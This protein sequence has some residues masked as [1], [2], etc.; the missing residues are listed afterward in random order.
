MYGLLQ[1]VFHL[2]LRETMLEF[3]FRLST[4]YQL[5]FILIELYY[6]LVRYVFN[7]EKF[8][9]RVLNMVKSPVCML[10][11]SKTQ[12]HFKESNLM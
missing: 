4:V 10:I 9:R 5:S 2:L 7:T 1:K 12:K 8:V 6:T 11:L 3:V